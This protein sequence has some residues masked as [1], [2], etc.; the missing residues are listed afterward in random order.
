MKKI[1]CIQQYAIDSLIKDNKLSIQNLIDA[2]SKVCSEELFNNIISIII[3]NS[4]DNST[5]TTEEVKANTDNALVRVLIPLCSYKKIST[6]SKVT[7]AEILRKYFSMT[8]SQAKEYIDNSSR[9][10]VPIHQRIRRKYAENLKAEL[11]PYGI[12]IVI[13]QSP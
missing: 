6:P 12:N 8:L 10:F 3:S 4:N 11:L 9:V 2:M 5:S 13:I 1:S 7:A